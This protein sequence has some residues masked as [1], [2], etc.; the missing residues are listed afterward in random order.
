VA[1]QVA[2][3]AADQT[4]MSADDIPLPMLEAIRDLVGDLL[5]R[6]CAVDKTADRLELSPEIPVVLAEYIDEDGDVAGVAVADL[7][8]ACRSGSALVM[9][10]PAVAEEAIRAGELDGDMLDCFREVVNVLT[11]LMNSSETPHV[12]LRAV[13]QSGQLL[14]GELRVL[15]RGER[16]RRRDYAVTI[17]EY[18]EGRLAVLS[19]GLGS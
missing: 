16:A 10:P 7:P 12:K 3:A 1:A 17:E 8:F 9:M 18:G 13:Y 19:R 4:P 15:L 6:G 2:G 11:R 14:P 5:S